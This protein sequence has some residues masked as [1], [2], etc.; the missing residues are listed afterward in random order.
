M[1]SQVG[2]RFD[3]CMDRA[4]ALAKGG[5]RGEVFQEIA[6]VQIAHEDLV[7]AE[8]TKNSAWNSGEIAYEIASKYASQKNLGKALELVAPFQ[9]FKSSDAQIIERASLKILAGEVEDAVAELRQQKP[10]LFFDQFICTIVGWKQ[11]ESHQVLGEQMVAWIPQGHWGHYLAA[12]AVLK[13]SKDDISTKLDKLGPAIEEVKD[14][15]AKETLQRSFYL[16]KA[17]IGRFEEAFAQA[18][19]DP[20]LMVDLMDQAVAK[21]GDKVE[22]HLGVCP[23]FF[24]VEKYISELA[25]QKFIESAKKAEVQ[26]QK[27]SS[28]VGRSPFSP[29]L[30]GLVQGQQYSVAI[31]VLQDVPKSAINIRWGLEALL[32]TRQYADAETLISTSASE[33]HPLVR[34]SF[35]ARYWTQ[36][37][38]ALRQSS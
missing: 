32:A 21:I 27:K 15:D 29:L 18:K 19:K 31:E 8:K 1:A 11:F 9:K 34:P 35:L 37:A 13:L 5:M 7:E 28:Y 14:D 6:R 2:L 17:K 10:Q 26:Y 23:E 3:T 25:R 30:K 22:Q 24:V 33:D 20:L 12:L 36:L 38:Y 16:L 4:F